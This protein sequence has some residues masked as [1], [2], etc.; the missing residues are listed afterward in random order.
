MS[1]V[2]KFTSF[3]RTVA[4]KYAI[5]VP[6]ITVNEDVVSQCLMFIAFN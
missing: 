6:V 2:R 3:L 5:F 4:Q 1:D